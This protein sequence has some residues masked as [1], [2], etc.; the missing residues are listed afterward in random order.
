MNKNNFEQNGSIT[1]TNLKIIVGEDISRYANKPI[2]LYLDY[3]S[4]ENYGGNNEYS[5]IIHAL[6]VD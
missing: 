2:S 3:Q 5:P 4:V 1:L 6:L